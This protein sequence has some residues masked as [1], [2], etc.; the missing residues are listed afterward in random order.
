MEKACTFNNDKNK[1]TNS[2]Y[3]PESRVLVSSSFFTQRK[4]KIQFAYT[5]RMLKMS[6]VI[7]NANSNRAV[8]VCNFH[9]LQK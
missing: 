6:L 9:R 1:I 2:C 7:V 5:T 8:P 4:G 3:N